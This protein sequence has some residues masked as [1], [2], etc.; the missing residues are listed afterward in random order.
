MTALIVGLAYPLT[1]LAMGVVLAGLLLAEGRRER[2][3]AARRAEA[4]AR[5]RW[6]T[7]PLVTD[8]EIAAAMHHINHPEDQ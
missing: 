1:L 6:V 8:D 5:P 2:R 7:A 4:Y 3:A